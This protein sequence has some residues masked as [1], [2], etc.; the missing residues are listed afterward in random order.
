[1]QRTVYPAIAHQISHAV[2]PAQWVPATSAGMTPWVYFAA[3]G[4]VLLG[5]ITTLT[6]RVMSTISRPYITM[7]VGS[8]RANLLLGSSRCTQYD[9]QP[10]L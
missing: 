4:Q 8:L 3:E 10:R 1:M 9:P 5:T 2:L 7:G 6:R